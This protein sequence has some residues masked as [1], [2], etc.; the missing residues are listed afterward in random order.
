[1]FKVAYIYK[2]ERHG[3]H[4]ALIVQAR[5][6]TCRATSLLMDAIARESERE[7]K[8]YGLKNT[9]VSRSVSRLCVCIHPHSS[10][11]QLGAI[12]I[13]G[14][15]IKNRVG[16]YSILGTVLPHTNPSSTYF[17]GLHLPNFPPPQRTGAPMSLLMIFFSAC[18]SWITSIST[19]RCN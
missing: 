14:H 7:R 10:C 11:N 16:F 9:A 1:M 17:L 8:H 5:D 12:H 2:C 15:H 13:E 3:A 6:K 4:M 19:S 18:F